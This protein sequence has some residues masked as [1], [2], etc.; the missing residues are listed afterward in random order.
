MPNFALAKPK[1][2]RKYIR[3]HV[4]VVRYRSA[5]PFTPVR[6]WLAP[7]TKILFDLIKQDFLLIMPVSVSEFHGA[8]S[9]VGKLDCDLPP[10]VRHFYRL[11]RLQLSVC[12]PL[13]VFSN[14]FPQL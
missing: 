12:E 3:C 7:L 11:D 5:K 6:I 9:L 1:R 13:A 4:R 14:L 10:I 8:G 2:L